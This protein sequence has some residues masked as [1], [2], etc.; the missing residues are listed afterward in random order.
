LAGCGGA[1]AGPGAVTL[2]PTVGMTPVMECLDQEVQKLGY[3]VVR[4][5]RE[6]GYMTAE[7]WDKKPEISRP[8]EYGGGDRIEVNRQKTKE[9]DF[10][11]SLTPSSF[12]IEWLFNGQNVK[13]AETR[14]QVVKD[15]T[16]LSERCRL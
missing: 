11:L 6:D 10:S 14:E 13:K 2:V 8:R 1:T 3:K 15:V 7:R 5:D 4:I 12:I 9:K 16:T